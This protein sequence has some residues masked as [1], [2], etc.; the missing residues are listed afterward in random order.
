MSSPVYTDFANAIIFV[1]IQGRNTLTELALSMSM[2]IM[3][4]AILQ[5]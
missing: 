2:F 3:L 4:F 1:K 5:G